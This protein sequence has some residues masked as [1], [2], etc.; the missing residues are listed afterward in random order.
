M[1]GGV[2]RAGAGSREPC[3]TTCQLCELVW[4]NQGCFT[5]LGL[6]FPFCQG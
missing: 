1:V 5:S 4:A 2:E 3:P 6:S